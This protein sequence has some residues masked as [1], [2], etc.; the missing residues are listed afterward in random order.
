MPAQMCWSPDLKRAAYLPTLNEESEAY[1]IDDSGRLLEKLGKTAGGFAWSS[2]SRSLYFAT[3]D[4]PPSPRP[5]FT[6]DERLLQ[7]ARTGRP[8]I[9]TP[10]AIERR[11]QTS[12]IVSVVMSVSM[13]MVRA[14]RRSSPRRCGPR[15]R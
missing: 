10:R 2:D 4:G 1:L 12:A 7:S 6:S 3:V 14:A 13:T 5:E 15:S 9:H 8:T 11:P